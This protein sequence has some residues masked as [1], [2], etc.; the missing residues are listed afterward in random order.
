MRRFTERIISTAIAE[1]PEISPDQTKAAMNILKGVQSSAALEKE[2]A[3][4]I[5]VTTREAARLLSVSRQTLWRL[6]KEN[7]IT[8]IILG[9]RGGQR[10]KRYSIAALKRLAG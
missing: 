9:S 4:K 8:P 7:A 3:D 2:A 10:I 1:D 5:L 6:E